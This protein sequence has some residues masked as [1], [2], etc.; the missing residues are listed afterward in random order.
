[1]E[2][3]RPKGELVE[4]NADG[5]LSKETLKRAMKALRRRLKLSRLDEES[6]LGHDPLS[7]GEKSTIVAVAPPEQYPREVWDRLVELGRLRD[8]GHGLLELTER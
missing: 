4:R 5:T 6:K 7:K 1:M 3:H 8:I 2:P